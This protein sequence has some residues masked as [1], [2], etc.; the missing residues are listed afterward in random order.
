M[1]EKSYF[2]D[3]S[4][5]KENLAELWI[6]RITKVLRKH[7]I[8]KKK[9]KT[10]LAVRSSLILKSFKIGVL[11]QKVER[12]LTFELKLNIV[13]FIRLVFVNQEGSFTHRFHK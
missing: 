6:F 2:K 5:N 12:E 4:A 11:Q 13:L 1:N 10:A 8:P 9:T 7:R 3:S